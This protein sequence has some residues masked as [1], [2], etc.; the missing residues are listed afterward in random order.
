MEKELRLGQCQ[1]GL[2]QLR[3]HLH[4]RARILKDKY[5]N[6]RHQVPNTRSRNLLERISAKINTSVEKYQ[7]A[8]AALL[9]LDSDPTAKWRL[10]LQ[11]LN[12][13]DIRSMS[14]A[15]MVH[16]ITAVPSN[17][18]DVVQTPRLLPGGI[19]PEGSRTLSWIW[20][21]ALNDASS[22]PG[23]HE[24]KCMHSSLSISFHLPLLPS[25]PY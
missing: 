19:I 17:E 25:F 21:G 23:Y 13:K 20:A 11:P 5:V 12:S 18:N 2:S 1:D 22:T 15:E 10:E 8:Y 9:A 4:S 16:P 6:V 3:D 14:D 24:C 7:A